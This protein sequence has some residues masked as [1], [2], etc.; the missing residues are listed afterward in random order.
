MKKIPIELSKGV[1]ER[2]NMIINEQGIFENHED[3]I[4][5]AITDLLE[6]YK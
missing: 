6:E 4:M 1:L 3:F 5:H 2:I